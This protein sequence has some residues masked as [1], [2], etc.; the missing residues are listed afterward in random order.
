[1]SFSVRSDDVGVI[2]IMMKTTMIRKSR[3]VLE[4]WNEAATMKNQLHKHRLKGDQWTSIGTN[5][6]SH[7][8]LP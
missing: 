5:T 6:A 4:Q 1:M 7:R 3:W 2:K 8:K